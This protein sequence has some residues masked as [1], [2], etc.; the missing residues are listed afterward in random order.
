MHQSLAIVVP[1]YRSGRGLWLGIGAAV[2]WRYPRCTLVQVIIV[3]DG[4]PD[5]AFHEGA[6]RIN[7]VDISLLVNPSNLGQ[8]QATW[9]G[10]GQVD[11]DWAMLLEDDLL[12]WP[13]AIDAAAEHFANDV[14]L[15]SLARQSLGVDATGPRSMLQPLVRRIFRWAGAPGLKDP[16]SPIKALRMRAFPAADLEPWRRS[17]HE[18]LVVLSRRTVEVGDAPLGWEDRPS[19]YTAG[20]LLRVGANLWPRLLCIGLRGPCTREASQ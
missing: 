11:A 1:T 3:D 18:G 4:S 20:R 15:V 12:E 8:S 14:D 16:T 6:T 9:R 13:S 7:G 19:R 10:L 17:I 5:C 2:R